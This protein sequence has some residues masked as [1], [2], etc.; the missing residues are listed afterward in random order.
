MRQEA[1]PYWR[2]T[3]PAPWLGFPGRRTMNSIVSAVLLFMNLPAEALPCSNP[4]QRQGSGPGHK[5]H[6]KEFQLKTGK[7]F[8]VEES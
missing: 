6:G 5:G 4:T 7:E 1:A 2:S 8:Q 3:L